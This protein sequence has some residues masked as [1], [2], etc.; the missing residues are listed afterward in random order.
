MN[1][2][3]KKMAVMFATIVACLLT[4]VWCEASLKTGELKT[5][6]QSVE[7]GEAKSASVKLG[8]GVGDVKLHGGAA[9]LMDATFT[10]NLPEWKPEVK[11]EVSNSAGKL[12]VTQPKT[13]GQIKGKTKN[14]WDI[15]LKND[16]PL[17]LSVDMGVGNCVADLGGLSVSSLEVN[18]G[19]G[20][21]KVL[22]GDR[23]HLA[24]LDL[25][26]GVGNIEV[27]LTCIWTQSLDSTIDVGVGG[28]KIRL[29]RDVGVRVEVDKG[30]GRMN[31]G[32]LRKQG[33]AYVNDAYGKSSIT[34]SI[35]ASVGVGDIDVTQGR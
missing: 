20:D 18:Q 19:V 1:S 4:T 31:A 28:I 35:K 16:F 27:D 24:K 17:S 34:L 26:S 11:Y 33:D 9:N 3:T 32:G 14:K 30:L 10:Y 29:P 6:R 2:M 22:S 7:V 8:L 25:N 15:G 23:P 13:Q 12:T 21:I 5:E